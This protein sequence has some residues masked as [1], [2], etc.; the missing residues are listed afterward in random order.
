MFLAVSHGF[1]DRLHPFHPRRDVLLDAVDEEAVVVDGT[2]SLQKRLRTVIR[3]VVEFHFQLQADLLFLRFPVGVGQLHPAC[4][5]QITAARI[6]HMEFRRR[7]LD[8]RVL[9]ELLHRDVAPQLF[10]DVVQAAQCH[11][12]VRRAL[13]LK[14]HQLPSCQQERDVIFHLRQERSFQCHDLETITFGIQASMQSSGDFFQPLFIIEVHTE[15]GVLIL[16]SLPSFFHRIFSVCQKFFSYYTINPN[17]QTA[18]RI[19][20]AVC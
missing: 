16:S 20:R 2:A 14:E 9:V 10:T 18:R 11:V 3:N 6:E 4:F 17:K 13:M 8:R 19:R 7:K 15:D 5:G 1:A 12:S